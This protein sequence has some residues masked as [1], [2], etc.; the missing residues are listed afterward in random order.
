MIFDRGG[1]E[2]QH[3]VNLLG[4]RSF[5]MMPERDS[6]QL[7]SPTAVIHAGKKKIMQVYLS[8]SIAPVAQNK[9][10]PHF[11]RAEMLSYSQKI[12]TPRNRGAYYRKTILASFQCQLMCFTN[13][14]SPAKLSGKHGVYP[15]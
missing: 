11:S 6:D 5:F 9:H 13:S 2:P 10:S 8:V 14:H 15:L 3:Q 12:P 1:S 4:D 7:R